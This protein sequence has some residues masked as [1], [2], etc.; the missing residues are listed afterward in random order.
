V[1][2]PDRND[3]RDRNQGH[4]LRE[5]PSERQVERTGNTNT[6]NNFSRDRTNIND[7]GPDSRDW[8]VDRDRLQNSLKNES[9]V[10]ER[11]YGK[12][13]NRERKFPNVEAGNLRPHAEFK[14][15]SNFGR[16]N[17]DET[18]QLGLRKSIPT[19]KIDRKKRC[20][21]L[22]RVFLHHDQHN[23][24][25]Q[26]QNGN[27]PKEELAIYTW[28]DAKLKDIAELVKQSY[29]DANKLEVTLLFSR[30]FPDTKT[31]DW[32]MRDVGKIGARVGPDDHVSLTE[33]GFNVGDYMDVVV[34][35]KK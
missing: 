24:I 22:M 2:Y 1:S 20:P 16:R 11:D 34:L 19:P 7:P 31:G 35:T 5:R 13:D 27:V 29:Q 28:Q 15:Q 25:T 18:R 17:T 14:Q 3:Q 10:R 4:D 8:K 21:F 9:E 12:R 32:S 33:V 6:S 23:E 30:V 26:F